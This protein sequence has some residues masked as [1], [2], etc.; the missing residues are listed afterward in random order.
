VT[1]DDSGTAG[2]TVSDSAVDQPPM[3]RVR[4]PTKR[5]RQRK[6][7][8]RI[9][10]IA[11]VL[12]FAIGSYGA[13]RTVRA[14]RMAID[15]KAAMLRAETAFEGRHL[16]DAKADLGAAH[17]EFSGMR[18][19]LRGL[20]P[21]RLAAKA[22]PLLRLQVRGVEAFS[23]AG[24]LLSTAGLQLVDAAQSVIEPSDQNGP[25]SDALEALRRIQ[26]PVSDGK[27]MLDEAVARVR[28]LDGYRLLGPLEAARKDLNRRLPRISELATSADRGVGAM[29][30]FIGGSGPRRYLL[31]S[32]NPDEVRPT[33]GYIGTYG[34]IG[35]EPGRLLLE[36]YEPT[37]N[38]TRAHPD[39]VVPPEQRSSAFRF[40]PAPQSL[41]NVNATP[42]F[43]TAARL[44]ASL[45]ERGG[46]RPVDGVI[47]V[48]PEFLAKV[49]RALGPVLVP[50]YGETVTADNVIERFDFYTR[51]AE[52]NELTL[53]ERKQFVAE[54]AEVVTQRVLEAPASQW[55]PL[56]RAIGE[57]FDARAAMAW[58][59]DAD[60]AQ[61]LAAE[62]W[63]GTFP[64]TVGDFFYN[65]ELA[66]ASKNGRALKRTFD[67]R[68]V[69][70][71]DGSGEVT[72]KMTLANTEPA[73]VLNPS[74]LSYI[75]FYGPTGAVLDPKSDKPDGAEPAVAGHPAAAWYRAA[76]PLGETTVTVVWQVPSL[77][78]KLADGSWEYGLWWMG[79]P[80]HSGDV[81]NL[82]VELPPGFRWSGPAPPARTELT[83][84]LIGIWS[85]RRR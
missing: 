67:H 34:V 13:F 7:R 26:G 30:T 58:S 77:A 4:V 61:A 41:A 62:A 27:A 79:L 23:D 65:A 51:Q 52:Q 22:V 6:R 59:Q 68:V 9:L 80:D 32:Q 47:T 8:Q 54:L 60:V 14:A 57:A 39:A 75:T 3:V 72:T 37:E 55:D 40:D 48:L 17:R 24:V 46:E 25:V 82:Q 38:W 2:P 12:L 11:A 69:L 35:A 74:S 64:A 49:L 63:D 1:P 66:Y 33:G 18:R 84:D 56:A 70:R 21:L 36:R 76:P 71:P 31:L 19:E 15:G 5:R 10:L 43:P 29:I 81:L 78:R 42:D 50:S 28:S 53:T 45:W 73:R 44:A 85:Y 16:R 20:G 83:E